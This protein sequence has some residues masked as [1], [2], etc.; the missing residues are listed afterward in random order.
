MTTTIFDTVRLGYNQA[1]RQL[2]PVRPVGSKAPDVSSWTEFKLVRASLTQM[3]AWDF[4]T[5]TGFGV[6]G[7]AVSGYVDPWDFDCFATFEAFV[8][9]AEGCGLG[10]V[11][12]R[13]RA[14]CEIETP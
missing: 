13:I 10:D 14:G 9:A 3:R 5:R 8:K 12:R 7:G 6:V 11:V 1:G 2:L 4:S